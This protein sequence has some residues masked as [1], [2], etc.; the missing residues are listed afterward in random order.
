MDNFSTSLAEALPPVDASRATTVNDSAPAV[1]VA[2]ASAEPVAPSLH[3]NTPVPDASSSAPA[4]SA[5]TPTREEEQPLVWNLKEIEFNGARRKIVMQDTGGPCS[6]LAI[7]NILILRGHLP[8]DPPG[9]TSVSYNYLSTHLAEHLLSSAPDV[10][11]GAALSVMPLTI[12][13]MDLNPVFTSPVAFQPA[14]TGGEL[15]LFAQAG[16]SLVHGWLADPSS[17]EYSALTRA[18]D[19]DA[20]TD[21][22]VAADV[23]TRGKLVLDDT[24]S[25][26]SGSGSGSGSAGP[27]GS[28]SAGPVGSSGHTGGLSAQDRQKVEDAIALRAWLDATRSQLTYHGLFTLAG[29]LGE[30]MGLGSDG[31][32]ALFRNAHLAVLFKHPDGSLYTL[33]TDESFLREPSVVWERLEDVDQASASFV[34]HRFTPSAPVGG[35]W[36][37]WRPSDAAGSGEAGDEALARQLQGEEDEAA[38]MRYEQR[39]RQRQHQ[40]NQQAQSPGGHPHGVGQG[41]AGDLAS[42]RGRSW[43]PEAQG[44]R[45]EKKKKDCIIM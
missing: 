11:I 20:A 21:V 10:D 12:K 15:A 26:P 38:R 5:R 35:D 18:R 23:L 2:P 34:D 41:Y 22:I 3:L 9:R 37:G 1:H 4:S 24:V 39:N 36:A 27:S 43:R 30:G 17:P 32:F 8:I 31:L 6:F 42:E 45:K 40:P 25:E 29:S 16:I 14:S 19:Y 44:E 13:G 7:C 28:G 33:A